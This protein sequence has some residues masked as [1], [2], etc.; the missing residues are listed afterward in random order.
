MRW[1]DRVDDSSILTRS[2]RNLLRIVVLTLSEV[3]I[4]N[5]TKGAM[6]ERAKYGIAILTLLAGLSGQAKAD[7]IVNGGFETGDFT[8]WTKGGNIGPKGVSGPG[9]GDGN[10]NNPFSGNFFAFLGSVGRDGTLS[11]R[12]SALRFGLF[13]RPI[14]GHHSPPAGLPPTE[15]LENAVFEVR[16]PCP[17]P[18]VRDNARPKLPTLVC[19]GQ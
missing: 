2:A 12:A 8:G 1:P 19:S 13:S 5:H 10:V 16:S 6:N 4:P 14:G 17:L 7:L 3:Q 11:H 9:F 15:I 18:D